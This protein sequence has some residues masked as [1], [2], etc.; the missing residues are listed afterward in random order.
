MEDRDIPVQIPTPTALI[1]LSSIQQAYDTLKSKPVK[2]ENEQM[3]QDLFVG[4]K[5]WTAMLEPSIKLPEAV[6]ERVAHAQMMMTTPEVRPDKVNR[7]LHRLA[8]HCAEYQQYLED[9]I[10]IRLGS[11]YASSRECEDVYDL[12]GATSSGKKTAG[13]V[14]LAH[15]DQ[16]IKNSY[17][18]RHLKSDKSFGL[19]VEKYRRISDLNTTLADE[20]KPLEKSAVFVEKFFRFKPIF[21]ERPD[22]GW[23]KVAK[24]ISAAIAILASIPTIGLAYYIHRTLWQTKDEKFTEQAEEVLKT[25]ALPSDEAKKFIHRPR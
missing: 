16:P 18:E 3:K 11:V 2:D 23:K 22:E 15:W 12:V 1:L 4:L 14:I 13:Q 19:I 21:E 20:Q 7:S 6:P 9:E 10:Q 5:A 8:R 24:A 17:L 25:K